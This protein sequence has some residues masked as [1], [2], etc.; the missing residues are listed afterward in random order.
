MGAASSER[1]VEIAGFPGYEVSDEGRIRS[2]IWRG[3]GFG[4]L[5]NAE[6]KVL[7]PWFDGHGYRKV[8]LRRDG[9]THAPKVCSLV[10]EAF[11]GPRPPRSDAC[12][13]DGDRSNDVLS[14]LRWDTRAANL[15][16]CVEHG[17]ITRGAR[18]GTAKLTEEQVLEIREACSRGESQSA[19]A[20]RFGVNQTTVSKIHRRARWGWL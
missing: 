5:P 8:S 12:H 15:A 20:E 2:T 10:L 14:N 9:R 19:I 18:T 1:W 7:S 16:D 4:Q 3:K 6:P 17:T 11:V 13:N